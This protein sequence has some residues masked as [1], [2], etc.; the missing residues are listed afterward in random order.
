MGLGEATQP[1]IG[2]GGSESAASSAL[3]ISPH[4]VFLC[5]TQLFHSVAFL[6]KLTLRQIVPQSFRAGERPRTTGR[7]SRL[8]F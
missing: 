3:R 4:R 1:L 8:R 5:K 6:M 7:I 2:F